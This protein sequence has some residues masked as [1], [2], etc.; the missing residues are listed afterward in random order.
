MTRGL[1]NV[2]DAASFTGCCPY[3]AAQASGTQNWTV[4]RSD[5]AARDVVKTQSEWDKIIERALMFAE[6]ELA[7]LEIRTV[8]SELTDEQ[9]RNMI[10]LDRSETV[11]GFLKERREMVVDR[12]TAPSEHPAL[13]LLL[14]RMAQIL[15]ESGTREREVACQLKLV[16]AVAAKIFIENIDIGRGQTT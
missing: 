1:S 11:K 4:L 14:T 12:F 15:R 8:I 5:S 9:L 10:G 13:R 3:S 6:P 2:I 7:S 16:G